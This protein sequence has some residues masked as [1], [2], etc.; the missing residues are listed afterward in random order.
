[1]GDI[2]AKVGLY[3]FFSNFPHLCEMLLCYWPPSPKGEWEVVSHMLPILLTLFFFSLGSHSSCI[4]IRLSCLF[5]V[6]CVYLVLCLENFVHF[7]AFCMQLHVSWHFGCPIAHY[8]HS[9]TMPGYIITLLQSAY[10]NYTVSV[11]LHSGSRQ[12]NINDILIGT[13]M[14]YRCHSPLLWLQL[15]Y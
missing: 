14:V 4:F 12:A 1:M 6:P 9:K 5:A 8:S 10:I 15:T 7:D 2:K 13:F 11:H 3:S